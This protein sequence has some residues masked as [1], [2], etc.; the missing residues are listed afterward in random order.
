MQLTERSLDITNIAGIDSKAVEVLK[1]NGFHTVKDLLENL[2]SRK[3][4]KELIDKSTLNE[5]QLRG[6]VLQ[7]ELLTIEGIG[8][9]YIQLL[10]RSNINS[11]A[12][13]SLEDADQLHK[14]LVT[15]NAKY[16]IVQRLPSR[17]EVGKW[18]RL[19][20]RSHY[21]II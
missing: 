3:A 14:K 6:W 10:Q 17:K 9:A 16:Q 18:I 15:I 20:G 2:S 8:P 11:A 12:R 13:L 5:K 21:Q 1:K 4:R 7:A 19:A